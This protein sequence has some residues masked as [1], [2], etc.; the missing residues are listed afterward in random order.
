MYIYRAYTDIGMTFVITA[1][2]QANNV[3]VFFLFLQTILQNDLHM[4]L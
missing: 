3:N 1:H 2:I 4:F